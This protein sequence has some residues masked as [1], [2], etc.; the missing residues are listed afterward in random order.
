MT[1]NTG[2]LDIGALLQVLRWEVH[3]GLE[4]TLDHGHPAHEIVRI[5]VRVGT[6]GDGDTAPSVGDPLLPTTGGWELEVVFEP[7][8]PSPSFRL[9]E[10]EPGATRALPDHHRRLRGPFDQAPVTAISGIGPMPA[11]ALARS[12]IETVAEL[13]ALDRSTTV[14]LGGRE[15]IE[16]RAKARLTRTSPPAIARSPAD[17]MSLRAL[18]ELSVEELLA[19]IGRDVTTPARCADLVAY[20]DVLT[21]ALGDHE[22]AATR[23]RRV[24]EFA[25]AAIIGDDLP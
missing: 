11:V 25:S 21:I 7:S 5:R 14:A 19:L 8:A 15:M 1:T 18:S 9:T 10:P 6:S 12:G 3:R 13:A 22:L 17:D 23:L 16:L 4:L 24:R 2:T 20:L